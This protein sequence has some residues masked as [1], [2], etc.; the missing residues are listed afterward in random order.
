MTLVAMPG[1]CTHNNMQ[2]PSSSENWCL[3][4]QLSSHFSPLHLDC[5]QQFHSHQSS[6]ARQGPYSEACQHLELAIQMCQL[7]IWFSVT[8]YSISSGWH[9]FTVP[10]NS[11]CQCWEQMQLCHNLVPDFVEA[12]DKHFSVELSSPYLYPF[13]SVDSI[14]IWC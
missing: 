12:L 2:C 1:L 4:Y 3:I 11:Q 14:P 5:H 7:F 6:T 13:H 10:E 9:M 8:C